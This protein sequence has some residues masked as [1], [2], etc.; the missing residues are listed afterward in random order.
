VL[1]RAMEKGVLFAVST[2]AHHVSELTR[3]R[4]GVR[5]AQRG[6]VD[7]DRVVNTWDRARFDAWL[8]RRR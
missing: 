5:Q 4:W 7:P 8:A 3:T 1:R 6:W 2:D